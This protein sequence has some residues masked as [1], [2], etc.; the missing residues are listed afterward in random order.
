MPVTDPIQRTQSSSRSRWPWRIATAGAAAV[1]LAVTTVACSTEDEPLP[2]IGYAIDN[3]VTSYNANTVDGAASGAPQALGRVLPGFGYVG[4]S[5]RVVA[6]TDIGTATAMPGEQLTV[7]Y[8]LSP[9]SVYSDGVPMSCDDLVLTWAAASGK[10]TAPDESG[11]QLNV[12]DSAR[13]GGYADI[14]RIDCQA[15]SKDATVVFRQGRGD[16][17]WK[18]LFGA[19]ELLPA[20]VAARVAGVPDLVGAVNGGDLDAVRRIADFWNTGWT[21]TPGDLDLTLFPSAGPYRVESYTADEGLVLVANERW[22]G[23]RPATDRIVVWPRGTDAA[24]AAEDGRIQV[25]DSGEGALRQALNLGEA[26]DSRTVV[27]RNLEQLVLATSGVFEAA[28]ARR[29]FALCVPRMQLFDELGAAGDED[30]VSGPVASRLL[31]PD[32]P[33]YP[34]V[35]G[36]ASRYAKADVEAARGEREASN[37]DRMEVRIG[38]LGPDERRSRTVELIAQSCRD[39]GIE[40]VDA[41]SETFVPS[42]LSA[43]D[44]DAVLAGTAA[45]AGAG[46]SADMQR[47]REA[48]NSAAGSN[49]GGYTNGR[50]DEILDALLITGDSATIAGLAAEGEAILWSDMPTVPL[51]AQPRTVGFAPGMRAAVVNPT[52]A[53]AG[54]NMDRWIL[55]G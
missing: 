33:L 44:V 43:G 40:V 10:F 53:G 4:P 17:D 16:T 19:T 31:A 50:I 26:V 41:G 42:Q 20:H 13:R 8:R 46:G 18:S 2:S 47:A 27:S 23:N 52:T 55:G 35:V 39:A 1:V 11:A 32:S 5:G 51:F 38:Y 14:E 25:V 29:A 22:W 21:L 15:G 28:E 9:N 7:Q 36:T 54:W 12:F 48:L 34:G 24:A 30:G 3:T 45:V 6:D 37:Q 49:I